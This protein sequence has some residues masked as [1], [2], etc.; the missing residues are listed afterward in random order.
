[1]ELFNQFVLPPTAAHLELL[2]Y[3][4][5]LACL[6]NFP[7]VGIVIGS[8]LLSL[9]LSAIDRD[10]SN[11]VCARVAK[12]LVDMALPSRITVLV[13]GILPLPVIWVIYGQWFINSTVN[14]MHLLPGGAFLIAAGLVVLLAYR[15]G[16]DPAGRNSTVVMGTGGMGLG[17]LLLGCYVMFGS[18]SRF[19]DPEKWFA[20]HHAARM[21]AS[22]NLIWRFLCYMAASLAITGGAILFFSFSWPGKVSEMSDADIRLTKNLG[23]GVAIAGITGLP[24]LGFLYLFTLPIVSRSGEIYWLGVALLAVLFVLFAIVYR[25]IFS[26]RPRFGA[27]AFVLFV[28]VFLMMI[29]GDQLTLVSATKEHIAGLVIESEERE[30]EI[31][32]EREAMRAA[33][34][35]PDVVRGQEVFNSV[36]M[37][38]HQMDERLVGPPLNTVLPKY[39]GDME[40]L[41]SFIQKPSKVDPDYPPMPAPGIPLVDIKSVAA[42]LLGVGSGDTG[43]NGTDGSSA[44]QPQDQEG[45][46]H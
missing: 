40:A 13:F 36:C 18:V 15:G 32:L 4:L 37:T 26:P 30:A 14:T 3:L 5:V 31:D 22:W 29:V 44:A 45:N 17:L 35:T 42:Y 10:V 28:V 34:I 25:T 24:V 43:S 39:A 21:L 16:L 2:R 23:A 9:V 46:G 7:Y 27:T 38:C 41:V 6:I 1:M 8:T 33:A 19:W 20:V 11:P 12:N